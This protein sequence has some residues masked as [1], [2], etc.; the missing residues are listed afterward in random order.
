MTTK[1]DCATR[2][3]RERITVRTRYPFRIAR[4]GGSA[5]GSEIFR[6]IVSVECDGVIGQGEAAP[7][8]YYGQR[9][10]SVDAAID[11]MTAALL[12]TGFPQNPLPRE[13][14]HQYAGQSAALAA[15]DAAGH[16]WR[17]R[18]SNKTVAQRL[19]LPKSGAR[20]SYSV[21]IDSVATM[22]ARV[23]DARPFGA[24][25]L[26]IGADHDVEVFRA[27][28]EVWDKPI[29]VDANASLS[30]KSA[31]E[32][33]RALAPF[34]LELIEQPVAADD[35]NGLRAVRRLGIAPV[36]ADESCVTVE[37]VARLAGVVDGVNVKIAKCGG[38]DATLRV[39]EAARRHDLR[40]MIGC[41][42]ET[43]LGI[44]AALALAGACDIFDLDAHLLLADDPYEGLTLHD[45]VLSTGDGPGLGVRRKPN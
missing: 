7:S 41:M 45:E 27:I 30:A 37:D 39:I 29:R 16:D 21:G 26:K 28:R 10:E 13:L 24:L 40:V 15:V 36:F 3:S 17:G 2:I 38:I 19:G 44:S 9:I 11:E 20:T 6:T 43:S 18:A 4:A 14:Y 8:V 32:R 22:V 23:E 12:A 31:V 5:E 42:V 33:I 1:S 34:G 25:K 35:V